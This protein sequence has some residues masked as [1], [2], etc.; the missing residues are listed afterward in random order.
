M[1]AQTLIDELKSR[2]IRL[3]PLPNGN[4]H[5]T[6]KA[7]LTAELLDALRQ[8]K[9]AL[10]ARLRG[11]RSVTPDSRNP[12]V[13]SEVRNKIEAIEEEARTKGW[14][15]E[16]LWNAGYWNC[17]RGLAALLDPGDEIVEVTPY[18]IEILKT[19]H[20]VLK[21]RRHIA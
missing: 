9:P 7:R 12:L 1:T 19:R 17:P 11:A 21:F 6:P 10:L 3:E 15:A 16:L 8:H 4:L 5:I 13:G 18:Y 2:G 14:P 20:D